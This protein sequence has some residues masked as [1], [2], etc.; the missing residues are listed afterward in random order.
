MDWDGLYIMLAGT[1]GNHV[2]LIRAQP[3]YCSAKV[4]E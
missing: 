4:S 2:G 3:S 1:G